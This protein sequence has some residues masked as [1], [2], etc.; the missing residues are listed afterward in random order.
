MANL[1]HKKKDWVLVTGGTRGIG[2]ALVLA[3]AKAGYRAVFTYQ[4]SSAQADVLSADIA[5]FGG[6]AFGYQC[7]G[8][9]YE[10][11]EQ[12]CSKLVEEYGN[13][14]GLINNMGITGD[15]LVFSM[16]MDL[17][18]KVINTNLNSAVYF[19]KCLVPAMAEEGCGR[20]INM[21]SV[22]GLKGNKGQLAYAATKA[23]MLGLTKTLA[24]EVARFNMTVNAV[25]PGFIATEMV[26]NIDEKAKKQITKQVP[27]KRLGTVEEVAAMVDFLLGETAGYITG[28]TFVIDGGLTV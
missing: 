24:L 1:D 26:D 19:S 25:A 8:S 23:G 9:Q 12:L 5:E 6:E 27:L 2:K 16:D 21:S 4:S 28:Q 10:Q 14:F 18:H 20:I 22:T 17:Y 7:D 15:Q 3:L 13:P 11:V